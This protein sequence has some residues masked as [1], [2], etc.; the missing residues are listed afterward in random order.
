MSWLAVVILFMYDPHHYNIR[1]P[2]RHFTKDPELVPAGI[3]PKPVGILPLHTERANQA[4]VHAVASPPLL[5]SM[6]N[7]AHLARPQVLGSMCPVCRRASFQRPP[8]NPAACMF[9]RCVQAGFVWVESR[10]HDSRLDSSTCQHVYRLQ[11][12]TMY[13]SNFPSISV[14]R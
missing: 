1:E 6:F 14:S 10:S 13:N 9:H 12:C 7:V 11:L 5:T 2:N 4:A 3:L 8:S